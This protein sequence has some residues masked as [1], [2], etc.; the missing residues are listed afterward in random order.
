MWGTLG[1]R[2]QLGD[3][4]SRLTTSCPK[5][6]SLGIRSNVKIVKC[7]TIGLASAQVAWLQYHAPTL[8]WSRFVVGVAFLAVV[9]ML[10]AL[11]DLDRPEKSL[12][13]QVHGWISALAIGL[14]VAMTIFSPL[15]R[16]CIRTPWFIYLGIGL[17]GFW[18][19]L[20]A[21]ILITQ[22]KKRLYSTK[23][24]TES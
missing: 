22:A 3:R 10:S 7:C 19:I 5:S 4:W 11:W 2:S 18:P 15:D 8:E 17:A 21:R 13:G 23:P 20:T 24:L 16:S 12:F 9:F 1:S 6:W 14:I